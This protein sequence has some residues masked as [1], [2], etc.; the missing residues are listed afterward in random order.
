LVFIVLT[1]IVVWIV[2]KKATEPLN[3]LKV[4]LGEFFAF[5]ANEREG[6]KPFKVHSMDEIGEMVVSLNNN[7]SKT[8]VGLQKDKDAIKQSAEICQMASIGNLDVRI[9]TTANNPEINNLTSI[10]NNLLDSLHYNINRVLVILDKYS[11]DEYTIRINSKGKTVGEIKKLFDQ[12]DHLGATLT[13]LSS[14]NLHNGKALQQTSKIFSKNVN[15]LATSSQEQAKSLNTASQNLHTIT[16]KLSNTTKNAKQMLSLAQ[17]V[18]KSSNKGQELASKTAQSMVDINTKVTTISE[19]IT[20]IDQ[21]SFQTN[22]LSLNAAV[23]AATAGEAGKGFAVVAGEVRNL[24]SRSAEAAKEIKE[25]V[26]VAT[27]Q[28]DIGSKIASEMI[29]GY[30]EL[31]NNITSTTELINIV[32]KDSQ[33]QQIS[34]EEIS[35]SINLIDQSTQ[36][37]AKVAVETDIVAQQ[38]SDIAQKIVNDASVKKFHGKDKIKIRKK[39]VDPNY[40]GPERRKIEKRLRT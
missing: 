9:T 4:E 16:Q 10:V 19:A 39:I 13:R 15:F 22:I 6:I 29:H 25:L 21:I 1:I 40:K 20:V 18:K 36:E 38:A 28:T 32:T 26:E 23:E 37:N 3:N 7:I 2:A 12:V 27:E 34:I 14:Q 8:I 31:N 35:S 30:E 11:Q 17:E 33:E 24:A 5:L